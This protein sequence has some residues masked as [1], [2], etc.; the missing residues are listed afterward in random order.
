VIIPT[1]GSCGTAKER[2]E[3]KDKD[4]TCYDWFFCTRKLDKDKVFEKVLKK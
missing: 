4:I 1:A 2:M 3:S